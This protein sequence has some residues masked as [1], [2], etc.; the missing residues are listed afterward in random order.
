MLSKR[1]VDR[2]CRDA[3]Q[4]KQQ[5]CEVGD[6][7]EIGMDAEDDARINASEGTVRNEEPQIS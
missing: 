1:S 4:L 7:A 5:K 2:F 3:S 6:D